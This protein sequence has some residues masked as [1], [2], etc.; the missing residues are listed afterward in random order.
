[1]RIVG[2]AGSVSRPSRSRALLDGIITELQ[3]HIEAETTIV[4]L[5]NISNGIGLA[6]SREQ[7]SSEHQVVLQHIE[8]A[9]LLVISVPVYR[10]AYPGLFKHLFDLVDREALHGKTVILAATGGSEHHT[11]ILEY[12]L[13]PLFS[14]FGA[15]TVPTTIYGI[16]SDLADYRVSSPVIAARIREAASEALQLLGR[17]IQ[18]LVA[19]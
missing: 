1:M 18:A 7:L 12:Q 8:Q 5:A 9:D 16:S 13:R 19:A 3:R 11:L 14:F 6:G 10:A 4:D 17:R 2:V 15:Y